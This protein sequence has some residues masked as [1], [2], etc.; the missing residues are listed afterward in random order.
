MTSSIPNQRQRI[1]W[2]IS[3]NEWANFKKS[4]ASK[5]MEAIKDAGA[6]QD[7]QV[8]T[9]YNFSH[10]DIITLIVGPEEV[11]MSVHGAYLTRD[12]EF[13]KAALKKEWVKDETR[14]IKLPEED[15]VMMA[16]Y[17]TFV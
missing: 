5:G 8:A 16:H 11:K 15:P 2:E 4:K 7:V 1:M 3:A 17:M 14:V 6:I 12:S 10:D 9:S 13:F